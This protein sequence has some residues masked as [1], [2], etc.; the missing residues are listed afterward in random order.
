MGHLTVPM[1]VAFD[2]PPIPVIVVADGR[3][4]EMKSSFDGVMHDDAQLLM[5][6]R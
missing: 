2:V 1:W 5:A 3:G 6:M 4:G